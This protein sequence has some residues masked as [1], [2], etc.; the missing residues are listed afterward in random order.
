MSRPTT[1]PSL[2]G[3]HYTRAARTG[4]AANWASAAPGEGVLDASTHQP[5]LM[6]TT[7]TRILTT[8]AF[9]ALTITAAL[10]ETSDQ[11]AARIHDAAVAACAPERATGT[12]PGAHY[13]AIDNQC[14][15]RISR[16]AMTKYEALARAKAEERS[17]L[18]QK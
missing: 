17:K 4:E 18:A 13:G 10:A 15:Y 12:L 8:A 5:N 16:S 11:L 6:E 3:S 9:L 2:I 14:I 7:M 1:S